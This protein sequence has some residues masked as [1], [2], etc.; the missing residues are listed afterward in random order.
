MMLRTPA[1][2]SR[3]PAKTH[4]PLSIDSSF[5]SNP[6][7]RWTEPGHTEHKRRRR[8]CAGIPFEPRESGHEFEDPEGAH[9]A[10][11]LDLDRGAHP[12]AHQPPPDRRLADHAHLRQ[13]GLSPSD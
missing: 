4:Q 11:G 7:V 10:W 13:V 1:T 5:M 8:R 3:T 2:S 12:S 9:A 6:F